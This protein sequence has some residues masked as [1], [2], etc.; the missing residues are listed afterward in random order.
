VFESGFKDV[1][2]NGKIV[3]QLGRPLINGL[4]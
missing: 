3:P 4:I 1:S 2:A